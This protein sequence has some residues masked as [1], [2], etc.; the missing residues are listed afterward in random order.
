MRKLIVIFQCID[1]FLH[2]YKLIISKNT[3][4]IHYRKKSVVE[5]DLMI[6]DSSCSS[7]NIVTKLK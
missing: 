5:N 4:K 6:N 1:S 2:P 7:Q 3:F